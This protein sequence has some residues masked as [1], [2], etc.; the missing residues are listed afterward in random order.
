VSLVGLYDMLRIERTPNGAFNVP[1]FG[2]VDDPAMFAVLH[3]Y[4]PYHGVEDGGVYPSVRL[5]AGENDPRVEP[6]QSRKM[7]ARLQAA[8]ASG[9]PVLLRTSAASGH[10]MSHALSHQIE[11]FA[12]IL[13]FLVQELGLE[14]AS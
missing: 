3:A 12:D 11:E 10:G 5:A 7:A 4:S 6:W 13:T 9:R 2:S 1:E 14:S 8:T